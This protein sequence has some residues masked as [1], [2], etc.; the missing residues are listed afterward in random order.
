MLSADATDH[1]GHILDQLKASS[2]QGDDP[3]PTL[4]RREEREGDCRG[5]HRA[6]RCNGCLLPAVIFPGTFPSCL[7]RKCDPTAKVFLLLA[8]S[9]HTATKVSGKGGGA[10]AAVVGRGD[11]FQQ[12]CPPCSHCPEEQP[13]SACQGYAAAGPGHQ[14]Y[15]RLTSSPSKQGQEILPVP[16]LERPAENC[17][18]WRGKRPL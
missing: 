5:Q 16:A 13:A 6:A 11:L 18:S 1:H 9:T 14:R 17:K 12:H 7:S 15:K 3:A 10:A 8:A 2:F 4:R